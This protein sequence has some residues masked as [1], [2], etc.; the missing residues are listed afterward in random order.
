MEILARRS[1]VQHRQE[2]AEN[3]FSCQESCS[4][5]ETRVRPRDGLKTQKKS[6][7]KSNFR[8]VKMI[9]NVILKLPFF[10]RKTQVSDRKHEPIAALEKRFFQEKCKDERF[11]LKERV[12]CYVTFGDP[13]S[14]Q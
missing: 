9:E 10:Q 2:P 11:Q 4:R 12:R 5:A 13:I 8:F 14:T 3:L 1:R 6:K 7:F